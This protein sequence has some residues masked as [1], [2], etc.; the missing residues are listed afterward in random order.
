MAD[1]PKKE[2]ND[3]VRGQKKKEGVAVDNDKDIGSLDD[4]N[5]HA[6]NG[7]MGSGPSG[8]PPPFNCDHHH[9]FPFFYNAFLL[10]V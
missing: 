9:N 10:S 7:E 1:V 5:N 4:D 8:P 3:D 6:M 2:G